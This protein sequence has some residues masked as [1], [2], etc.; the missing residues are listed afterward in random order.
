M[1]DKRHNLLSPV[2]TQNRPHARVESHALRLEEMLERALRLQPQDIHISGCSSALPLAFLLSQSESP[3]IG[4]LPH[5]VIVS[6]QKKAEEFK[7]L[8]EFFDP[9]RSCLILKEFDV[10]PYSGLAPQPRVIPAR[11]RFLYAALHAQ[12]RSPVFVSTLPALLQN[13]LPY[14]VFQKSI[15][16]VSV[17]DEIPSDFSDLL[18]SLGYRAAPLVEDVGQYAIR[19]GIIDVFSPSYDFPLRFELFGDQ[20]ESLRFFD[21]ETQQSLQTLSKADIIPAQ[22]TLFLDSEYEKLVSRVRADLQR[23]QM[24]GPEVDQLL[25][26][27]VLKQTFDG[28]EFLLPFFYESLSAPLEYFNSPYC[29]WKVDSLEIQRALDSWSAEI[30]QDERSTSSLIKPPFGKL[31]TSPDQMAFSGAEKRVTFSSLSDLES[32]TT[33][34][35]LTYPASSPLDLTKISLSETFGTETWS[36]AFQKRIRAYQEKGA[37][38]WITHKNI[39]SLQKIKWALQKMELPDVEAQEGDYLWSSWSHAN[40]KEILLIPRGLDESGFFAEEGLLLLQEEDLIGKRQ[41]KSSSSV[42]DFQK[43]AKR[44]NFGDLKPGDYVVHVK[45]G[46]GVYDGLQVMNIGGLESEFIQ[47]SYKDKDRLY[48]PVYRINQLQKYSSGTAQVT[49][50]KLGGIGWEKTKTKVRGYLRDLAADLLKLY[51]QRAQLQRPPFSWNEGDFL[52]FEKGFPF[53]ETDDQLRAIDDLMKDFRSARPMDRLICG[54]VGFGKTEVAM[55]AAF[56][57]ASTGKQVA[58]LAPTTV[59]TFQHMETFKKRFK[60]CPFEIRVLNRFVTPAESKKTLQ[61]LQDGK[62]RILIGTH[63]ILSQDIKFKDLGLLIVDEE[64]KFGVA[65]KEKL[66]KLKVSID[67]LALSATPIPRTLNMSLTGIRDLSLINSAPVDRLPTRTFICRFEPETIRKAILSEIQRAGQI[68]FIN[69]RIE[70]IYGLADELRQIVPEARIRVAHG[71]MPEHD[72][73]KAMLEFFNHEIDILVCTAIVESGMDVP[74]ANTMFI[75][76]SHLFGLSQLYQLRGR[77]GRS[78]QRAYCYLILPRN[79]QIDKTAEERLKV[80]Q[81]NTA[82]GSGIKIAQYDLEL[83]GS[84]NIL[85][86]DQS[87]HINAVGYELYMDLLQ[88]ALAQARGESSEDLELDPEINLKI[89]ALIPSDYIPDIRLRLSYYKALSDIESEAELEQIENELKDQFGVPPEPVLN[90]MGLMLIRHLCKKLKVRDVSSGL[91]SI[92][93]HF[94]EKTPLKTET[95]ISL[96]SRE[97]KKYSI[98]PDSRLNIRLNNLSWGLVYEELQY[99]KTLT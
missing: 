76:E 75:H 41:R 22:E 83:R 57:V 24:Q 85:G 7:A 77:V 60:D 23:R 39:S 71:Q 43:K 29:L 99:L 82:L 5:V 50:D 66:R 90:L 38:V 68:Y 64:Q 44:L 12:S 94:T 6:D 13:T 79:R 25:R 48:L 73:E 61:E 32:D 8:I 74:R 28:H 30:S 56:L 45:H 87:G 53:E 62:V 1:N 9:L 51:A 27:L 10:S 46:I 52:K 4:S 36:S 54:D 95:L 17:G 80:I 63:R 18:S 15:Q 2:D 19:G 69:N 59:L 35:N 93:L 31:F 3:I 58:V 86:E 34:T 20:I 98:T 65:H 70:S 92:S 21:P 89:P 40:N 72:L 67:T 49:L 16:T 26:S 78:K 96:A 42:A 91:R 97:N 84:G 14:S 47:V 88:E 81:E 33:S 37:R 11:L 55:R